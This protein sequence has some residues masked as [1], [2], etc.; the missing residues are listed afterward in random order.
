MFLKIRYDFWLHIMAGY[1]I[2]VS[3]CFFMDPELSFLLVV[4]A[5]FLKEWYDEY[6][7]PSKFDIL[8]IFWTIAGG[9]LGTVFFQIGVHFGAL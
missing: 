7:R 1:I 6:Y 4:G 3:S 2:A 5:A 8:D 9:I